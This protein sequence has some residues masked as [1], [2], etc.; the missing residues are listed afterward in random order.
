MAN[1]LT[2]ASY[3]DAAALAAFAGAVD[4][5]TYEFENVALAA[6]D[7]LAARVPVRPGRRAL[8]VAQDRVAEKAFLNGIGLATA[9]WAAVDGPDFAGGGARRGSERRRS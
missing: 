7:A 2:T 3:D 4:V 8:E 9:P 5:V 6:V 1:A